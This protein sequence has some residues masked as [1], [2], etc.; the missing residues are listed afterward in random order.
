MYRVSIESDHLLAPWG[1]S[2]AEHD[3]RALLRCEPPPNA[4]GN[5][6]SPRLLTPPSSP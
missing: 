4:A 2:L 3:K 6:A 5:C 1:E